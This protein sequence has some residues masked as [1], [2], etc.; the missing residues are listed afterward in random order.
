MSKTML[1]VS[2]SFIWRSILNLVCWSS[3]SSY[4]IGVALIHVHR[5][6]G[7]GGACPSEIYHAESSILTHPIPPFL[8]Y[9]Y[10]PDIKEWKYSPVNKMNFWFSCPLTW[11]FCLFINKFY[12]MYIQWKIVFLLVVS[13]LGGI[14]EAEQGGTAAC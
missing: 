11:N 12:G 1:E 7:M 9:M 6:G 4:F 5:E 13:L 2:W 8:M 3:R 14:A 10:M